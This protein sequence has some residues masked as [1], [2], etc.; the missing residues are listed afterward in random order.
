MSFISQCEKIIKVDDLI[1]KKSIEIIINNNWRLF[2]PV[3]HKLNGEK[4]K[5]SSVNVRF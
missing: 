2:I 1:I 4:R 3:W 5:R